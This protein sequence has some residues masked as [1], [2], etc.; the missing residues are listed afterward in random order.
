MVIG[1]PL[2]SC[3][4][5]VCPKCVLDR[6]NHDRFEKH[7]SWHASTLLQLVHN[8]LCGLVPFAYLFGFKY[9]LT[10]IDDFSKCTWVYFLKL[11]SEVFYAFGLQV[12]CGETIWTSNAQVKNIEW[13]QIC[14][15]QIYYLLHSTGNSNTTYCSIY[16]IEKRCF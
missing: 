14:K 15:Q 16:T 1:L 10:F 7:A 12:P 4:D 3:K 13:S 8:D 11:K 5:G 9:F 2:I 6:H